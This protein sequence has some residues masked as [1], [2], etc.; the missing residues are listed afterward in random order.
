MDMT[1]YRIV[2]NLNGKEVIKN[3]VFYSLDTASRQLGYLNRAGVLHGITH[4]IQVKH[5]RR[6]TWHYISS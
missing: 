5:S 3:A 2:M 1:K 4:R 6:D